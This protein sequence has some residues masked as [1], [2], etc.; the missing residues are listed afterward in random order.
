M[1]HPIIKHAMDDPPLPPAPEPETIPLP[2]VQGPSLISAPTKSILRRRRQEKKRQ[3]RFTKNDHV[4][5]FD[6]TDIAMT[7]I[8]TRILVVEEAQQ[9]GNWTRL[10]F[11]PDLI[12]QF[13]QTVTW[14]NR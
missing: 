13:F 10:H 3:V 5:T 11:G 9:F 7:G 12:E 8:S 1:A 6:P 2:P 14:I 4:A